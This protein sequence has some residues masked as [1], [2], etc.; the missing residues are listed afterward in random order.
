[1]EPNMLI[2]PLIKYTVYQMILSSILLMAF[3]EKVW[4]I[5]GLAKVAW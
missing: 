3:I 2:H 4:K 5:V 1:M